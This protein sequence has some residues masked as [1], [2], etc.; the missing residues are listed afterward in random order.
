[1][2][3]G[4]GYLLITFFVG[5]VAEWAGDMFGSLDGAME[6]LG[7]DIIPDVPGETDSANVIS[8][9]LI[10]AFFAGFGVFGLVAAL[11]GANLIL[12]LLAASLSGLVFGI[13]YFTIFN[14]LLTQQASMTIK[15]SDLIGKTAHAVT[16]VPPGKTGEVVLK[17]K[18]LRKRYPAVEIHGEPLERGDIVRVE[19]Q[20]GRKLLVERTS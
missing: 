20:E 17:V 12:S 2:V 8:C 5:E 7:V 4:M 11:L 10:A 15:S 9:G 13:F 19:R 1:M 16:N 14:F 3:I 18:G 6:D